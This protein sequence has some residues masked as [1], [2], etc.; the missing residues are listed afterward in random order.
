MKPYMYICVYSLYIPRR[1]ISLYAWEGRPPSHP[2]ST[3][4][5]S[6]N[7]IKAKLC[8]LRFHLHC[9]ISLNY[10]SL[11]SSPSITYSNLMFEDQFLLLILLPSHEV[12]IQKCHLEKGFARG[13]INLSPGDTSA[14]PPH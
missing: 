12:D 8:N 2:W 13:N 3:L 14:C 9:K 1:M 6:T 5:Q 4:S 10:V 11:Y 7:S